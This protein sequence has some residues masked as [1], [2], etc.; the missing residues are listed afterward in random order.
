MPYKYM[1]G[2]SPSVMECKSNNCNVI[3][4]YILEIRK[5]IRKYQIFT[6]DTRTHKH[7][8]T[9]IP[10]Y[11][12]KGGYTLSSFFLEDFFLFQIKRTY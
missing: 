9:H 12:Y 11:I 1:T 10:R 6:K 8:H 2:W 4:F 5:I 3:Y 7:T